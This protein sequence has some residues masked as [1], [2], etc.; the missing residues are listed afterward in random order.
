[1]LNRRQIIAGMES[2]FQYMKLSIWVSLGVLLAATDC[3]KKPDVKENVSGLEKAFP[4]AV[5]PISPQP[6]ETGPTPAP[7]TSDPNTY[8]SLAL[9]AVHTNDYA[10]GVI[11]LQTV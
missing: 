1:M 8:V 11:A 2:K 4:A 10:G 5:V 6:V 3:S 7:R 9:S